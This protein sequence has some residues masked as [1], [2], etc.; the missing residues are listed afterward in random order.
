[1]NGNDVS[2]LAERMIGFLAEIG[3]SLGKRLDLIEGS[4]SVD[5]AYGT[6]TALSQSNES[7]SLA[8]RHVIL[9]KL[10]IAESD[11]GPQEWALLFHYL[12]GRLVAPAGFHYM[13]FVRSKVSGGVE[14]RNLGWEADE[15][16]E[17]SHLSDL[18]LEGKDE[19]R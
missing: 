16:E 3:P 15:Y 2:M 14:W 12:N 17:W 13:R 7:R 10:L 5:G 18:G 8:V 6:A 11:D 19:R 9:I 4:V 1:M